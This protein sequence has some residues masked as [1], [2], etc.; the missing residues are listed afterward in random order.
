[1]E[2]PEGQRQVRQHGKTETRADKEHK[3]VTFR[4]ARDIR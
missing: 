4:M 1:V 3:D 2:S